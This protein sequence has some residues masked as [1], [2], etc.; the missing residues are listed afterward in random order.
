MRKV[1]TTRKEDE[2]TLAIE[3][4]K[5]VRV[6]GL[7]QNLDSVITSCCLDGNFHPEPAIQHMSG[8]LGYITLSED[9]PYTAHVQ[10]ME[11]L[12][13]LV[14]E[15]APEVSGEPARDIVEG[16]RDTIQQVAQ[17]LSD[18]QEQKAALEK[19]KQELEEK[20]AQF[21]HFTGLDMPFDE[22]I[23]GEYIKVR[24]GFLPKASYARM[25]VAYAE[26]PHVLFVTCSEDKG[27]YWG[28]YFT[29]RQNAD[30]IDGIFAT[31]FFERLHLPEATGTPESIVK[32]L[33]GEIE[34]K[35]KAIADTER[36]I[37]QGWEN[38]KAT[39]CEIYQPR[40][41]PKEACE[42]RQYAAYR[43]NYFF[44]VGWVPAAKAAAFA[45]K[46]KAIRHMR[47]TVSDPEEVENA[48]PP[49]KLKNPWFVKPFEFFVDMYGLPSYGE[50][51]IPAFVALT[52]TVL[53]GIMFGDLGQG[54]VLAVGGFILWKWKK[55]ALARLIV[56]CG[57]SSMVFGFMFGSVFGFEEA[58]NPVYQAL[59]MSGKPISNWP[60][61]P[62]SVLDTAA[63]NP[64]L[65]CAI[66][67][68]VA[69]V[70]A[71]MALHIIAAVRKRQ[72]G[73]AIFSNNG[74]VGI[75]VYCGGVS[76]V[77][78]FMS[79][80]TFL[81]N[82]VAFALIG[83]G[84]VLL[85]FKEIL[86]G[87][88]DHH[89]NWKPE[90]WADYCMQNIFELLEYVLSYFSNTVSFLRV[91]AFVFVHAAMMMAIFSL[92]GEPVNPVVVILGNALIIALEGLL[93]GIQGL[94]LEFYE[95]FS[96]CYEGGGH[97]FK[98]V[99]LSKKEG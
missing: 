21:S 17:Q 63:I 8:S 60:G 76:F 36:Q 6:D 68:G 24:F 84:L 71:A 62:H 25:M 14:G 79:G 78:N 80:P 3:K 47:V 93:S 97:P 15:S 26:N 32:Q 28:L 65:I 23:K 95:M 72:W 99:S 40:K 43:D 42:L 92:A 7:L 64:I 53:F 81:P 66:F 13:Q 9:N 54:A 45:E 88:V 61:T 11:E 57:I 18:L 37:T 46:V 39:C 55:M 96:R 94:R 70:L 69:L 30:E 48:T 90:S 75:V 67:I 89:P 16:D 1:S 58:L 12:Y 29:P 38:S 5:L 44:L 51:D 56:P 20:K 85:F 33:A 4:M 41:W 83:G 74:L 87:L 73:E 59:G 27:G 98:G 82:T 52:F 86:I 2:E 91:G 50:M 22:I 77:S 49:T 35:Q 19:E 34:E 10:K 31:L